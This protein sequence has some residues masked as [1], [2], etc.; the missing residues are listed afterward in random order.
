MW[1]NLKG[2]SFH[3][4]IHTHTEFWQSS[5]HEGIEGGGSTATESQQQPSMHP[6]LEDDQ[7]R[8]FEDSTTRIEV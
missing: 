5:R 1:T 6:S 7:E 4:N 8:R 3:V 2:I